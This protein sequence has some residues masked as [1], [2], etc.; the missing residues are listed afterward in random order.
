MLTEPSPGPADTAPDPAVAGRIYAGRSTAE[1]DAQRRTRI[2]EAGLHLF[3]TRGYGPTS[4]TEIAAEADVPFRYVGRLFPDKQAVLEAVFLSVHAQIMAALAQ[5]RAHAAPDLP[6]QIRAGLH[7]VLTTL[8]HDPRRL[9]ISCLEVVGV[10]HRL[11]DMRRQASREFVD[12]LVRGLD[13][14]VE[15]GERLPSGY[16]LLGVGLVGAVEA[17][18]THWALSPDRSKNTLDDVIEAASVIY[19][20]TLGLP[21]TRST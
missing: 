19:V 11:E 21:D 16:A 18:L 7:A 6:T 20:R 2:L 17:L 8:A 10:S 9:R 5:A 1:R 14:A 15:A 4:M 13:V 3:G 12:Q